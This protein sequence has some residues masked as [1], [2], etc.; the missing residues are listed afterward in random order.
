MFA[1]YLSS[2][3]LAKE[4]PVLRSLGEGGPVLRSL[5][6]GG[7]DRETTKKCAERCDFTE[8]G[9][10]PHHVKNNTKMKENTGHVSEFPR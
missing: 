1:G 9:D 10:N 4:E 5:G 3:A 8:S 2:V 7:C 6:E